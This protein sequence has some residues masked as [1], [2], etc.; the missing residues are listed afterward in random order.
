MYEYD[1]YKWLCDWSGAGWNNRIKAPTLTD[2]NWVTLTASQPQDATSV[3]DFLA[4][5]AQALLNGPGED[6]ESDEHHDSAQDVEAVETTGDS[7][8]EPSFASPTAAQCTARVKRY[9]DGHKNNASDAS[10]AHEGMEA[11]FATA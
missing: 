5:E 2:E 1:V 9:R 6:P 3:T 7:E 10:R 4:K 11:V 8:K